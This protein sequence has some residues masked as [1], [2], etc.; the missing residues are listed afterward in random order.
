[1]WIAAGAAAAVLLAVAGYV[2]WQSLQNPANANLA[3][4]DR[5]KKEVARLYE[6]PTNEEPSV[7][8]LQDPQSV[9]HQEFY[10]KAQKDDYI[11]IYPKAQLALIY[12]DSSKKL[13]NVDNVKIDSK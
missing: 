12:R 13:I 11:L 9:Q 5:I 1:M 7:A 8:Q 2:V 6:L 4:A 10:Q 3:T